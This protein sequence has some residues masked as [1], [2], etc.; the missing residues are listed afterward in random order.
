MFTSGFVGRDRPTFQDA[1]VVWVASSV[2]GHKPP[3]VLRATTRHQVA[4]ARLSARFMCAGY[5]W[6]NDRRPASP[7]D[8]QADGVAV[9]AEGELTLIEVE[10]TPKIDARYSAIF[11]NHRWRLTNEGIS[12]V[13]YLCNKSSAKKVISY[14][15]K[16]MPPEQAQL[17][18]VFGILGERGE[19]LEGWEVA[20]EHLMNRPIL[21]QGAANEPVENVVIDMPLLPPPPPPQ[22]PPVSTY[23]VVDED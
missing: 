20:F 22:A 21:A 5:D 11:S 7:N 6:E 13:V 2:S 15:D 8:H 9:R 14:R 16:T 17:V 18:Q 4:V 10:L 12:S 23:Y 1:S 3:N 19:L